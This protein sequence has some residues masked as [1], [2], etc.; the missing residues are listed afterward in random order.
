MRTMSRP[1]GDI[2]AQIFSADVFPLS[3]GP[4]TISARGNSDEKLLRMNALIAASSF[5]WQGR[6]DQNGDSE[7][8]AKQSERDDH[9]PARRRLMCANPGIPLAFETI[10]IAHRETVAWLSRDLQRIMRHKRAN[11]PSAVFC[12]GF[13]AFKRW[14]FCKPGIGPRPT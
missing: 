8:L 4:E 10:S 3:G 1:R 13:L 14:L 2:D 9:D 6:G 7:S 11:T 5:S 12:C